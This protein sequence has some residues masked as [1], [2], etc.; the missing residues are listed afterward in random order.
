M[1]WAAWYTGGR[2]YSSR[3]GDD[4]V[5][6]PST[7]LLWITQYHPDGTRTMY[8]GG[9]WYWWD[10]AEQK[11]RYTPSEHWD[12]HLPPPELSC[13]SCYKRGDSVSDEEF[14]RVKDAAWAARE[15][16]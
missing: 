7:G 16:P 3:R 12:R 6:L 13:L 9:D 5:R 2:F 8:N 15:I 1:Q 11:F 14:L 10:A 4:W